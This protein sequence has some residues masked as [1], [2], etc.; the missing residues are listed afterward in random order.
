MITKETLN[1]IYS[2]RESRDWSK[3]HTPKD[4]SVAISIESAELLQYFLWNN[5]NSDDIKSD[6]KILEGIHEEIADILIY[7]IYLAKELDLDMDTIL[8]D[9]V[10]KNSDKY[11]VSKCKGSCKKYTE[12]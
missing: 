7:L 8:C 5:K 2:F 12:L 6:F 11:P 1:R 9:K 10:E 4:L 3:F